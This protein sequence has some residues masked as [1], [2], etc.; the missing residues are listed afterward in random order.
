[1]ATSTIKLYRASS[2]TKWEL[3]PER[4]LKIES[5]EDYLAQFNANAYTK[6]D[7]QYIKPELETAITVDLS[8][9]NASPLMP[10]YKYVSIK[11]SDD[12]ATKIYY[13]YVKKVVWRSKSAVRFELV[14]DVL[15]TFNETTDYI[16]KPNTKI[17]REHK[18]RYTISKPIITIAIG[19]SEGGAGSIVAGDSITLYIDQDGWVEVCKGKVS[20]ISE[21]NLTFQVTSDETL[22]DI[23]ELLDD[24]I[25]YH[26]LFQVAKD[27]G[28]YFEARFDSATYDFDYLRKIDR[29]PEGINPVLNCG[30]S[31]GQ[32]IEH[33]KTLLQQNWYLLYRNVENPMD[34][35]KITNPVEC[36]LIPENTTDIYI[37]VTTSGQLVPA[38]LNA[39]TWYYARIP[40]GVSFT[41]S[42]G[43]TQTSDANN[44][45]FALV[46]TKQ[47]NQKLAVTVFYK[48]QGVNYILLQATYDDISYIT[49]SAFPIPYDSFSSPIDERDW[50]QH[51]WLDESEE[52]DNEYEGDVIDGIEAL[53]RT[54]V[55]NIKLIKMPYCPYSFEVAS[56][57]L[58]VAGTDWVYTTITQA[59]SSTIK[60]IKLND[61][62]VKLNGNFV[63]TSNDYH[64]FHYLLNTNISNPSINDLRQNWT[65][66]SKLYN[67][68]FFRPT[69]V[70]DSFTFIMQLEKLN[71]AS[72]S[73]SSNRQLELKFTMTST[74]NSKFLF[75]FENYDLDVAE[76]NY[77]RYMNVC[78]NNEEVLYNIPYINYIRTGFN[79]DKKQKALQNTSNAIGIG[80]SAASIGVSLA[81]PSVPLKVAGVVASIVSFAMTTKNAVVSAIKSEED[82]KQKL[83]QKKLE[84]ASVEGSDDVDLMTEYSQN[85]IKYLEYKPTEVMRNLIFD[86]FFYAGY[87]SGRMGLPNHTT[88]CNFDYLECDAVFEKISAIPDD[89]LSELIN[90]FKHGVTYIHKTTRTSNKWDMEQKYEN[91]EN[92]LL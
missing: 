56:N 28:N 76:E 66:E 88:R 42:N 83:E 34:S 4:L 11:N 6:T 72:F 14:M 64:P 2:A 81:L 24:G 33:E 18:D 69:Y 85:R 46:I 20:Y 5:I 45:L 65:Y 44:D 27:I 29:I 19:N 78:R 37:G 35:T 80:L 53:D 87:A 67:S 73:D 54:D 77:S 10:S 39:N 49:F 52:W 75:T 16:F 82:L 63:K 55:K 30:T 31:E 25:Y 17:T 59:D 9:T 70:Y 15:N 7:F 68:E 1:M 84:S 38:T 86:L 40:D 12:S 61:L 62:N 43:Y 36:F 48:R 13:Y 90:C 91:W 50:I 21:E 3:L 60:V 47:Q 23:Q 22:Q 8:Q 51:Y 57:K 32:L 89:C 92:S 71:I 26:D 74:I 58:Q 79:Y 41:L